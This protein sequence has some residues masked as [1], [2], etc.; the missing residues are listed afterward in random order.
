M[1]S[2]CSSHNSITTVALDYE[3]QTLTPAS[4]GDPAFDWRT[5][6][7]YNPG[8]SKR[9]E[10]EGWKRYSHQGQFHFQDVSHRT[11]D[12]IG[13]PYSLWYN[14]VLPEGRILADACKY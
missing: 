8:K 7:I 5:V 14:H 9:L 6:S 11:G 13:S 2:G 3:L 4:K 12:K 1:G 10:S